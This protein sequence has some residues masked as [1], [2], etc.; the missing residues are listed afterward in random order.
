MKA[1]YYTYRNLNRGE[2][3]S[4]KH[5]GVVEG[6]HNMALIH[7]ATFQVSDAGR[8]RCLSTKKRNVHA[9]VVSN[10]MPHT[11]CKREFVPAIGDL[12][13]VKYNPYK[14]D[15]FINTMTGQ[16]VTEAK[17]VY[18]IDGRCYVFSPK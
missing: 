6:Y 17:W 15:T 11:L 14:G 12:E 7:D 16:P 4:T 13:E 10:E 2:L 8:Q 1:K 18:L 5:R 9:F 3:F